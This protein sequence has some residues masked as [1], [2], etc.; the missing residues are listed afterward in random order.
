MCRSK[1]SCWHSEAITKHYRYKYLHN[2]VKEDQDTLI[3][4]SKIL[5]ELSHCCTT[6]TN[7]TVT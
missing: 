5:I 3:E 7:K 2:S 6:L 4:Q 1:E